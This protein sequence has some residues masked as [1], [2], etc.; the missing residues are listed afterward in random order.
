MVRGADF[1]DTAVSNQAESK[2][3]EV[4]SISVP[5]RFS[6]SICAWRGA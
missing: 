1:D 2:R 6:T 4:T 5:L 3:A